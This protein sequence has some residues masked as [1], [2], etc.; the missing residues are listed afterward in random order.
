MSTAAILPRELDAARD[1]RPGLLALTRVEL[2]KAYDTRA[3]FWLLLTCVLLVVAVAAISIFA[4]HDGDHTLG[5]VFN[6]SSQ[7]LN[8]LLPV[9]GILLVT[10]EWSQRTAQITFTL[11][12]HRGR[13]LAAK[14]L[15]SVALALA[16]FV[17]ALAVSLVFTALNASSADGAWSL[18]GTLLGQTAMFFV[19]SMLVGAAFGA[20]FQLSAPAIV[21]SF[22]L[23]I[24][25]AALTAILGL[26]GLSA[27]TNQGDTFGP[28]TD[29]SMSAR[30]WARVG[31]TL[32]LWLAVPLAVGSYRFLR[33]EIR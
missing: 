17:V 25:Y 5:N 12:P 2:R 16:A 19:F 28:L 26:D 15:A 32:L 9:V 13:V 22:V 11:V 30:E 31:T 10:S 24:A 7:V 4:G 33:G 6:N 20:A 18:G 14:L 8:V 1:H 23:T 29:H 27:W 21:A 3:G